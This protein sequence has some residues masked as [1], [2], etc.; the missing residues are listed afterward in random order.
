MVTISH[1]VKKIVRENPLLE[2]FLSRKLINYASLA[3]ELHEKIELEYDKKVKH[4]AI[5]MALRRL[6]EEL[7]SKNKSV[8]KKVFLEDDFIIKENLIEIIIEK[9]IIKN[10]KYNELLK[11]IFDLKIQ[12]VNSNYEIILL[13]NK[14]MYEKIKSIIQ[15]YDLKI[16]KE[17][18]NLSSITIR[19]SEEATST[20][21]FFYIITKELAF[22]NINLYEILSTY[23]ELTLLLEEKQLIKALEVIK[24]LKQTHF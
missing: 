3:E 6:S 14:K 15:K 18:T 1:I 23:T 22:N 13:L 9:E 20:V 7:E 4:T 21:G 12:I 2:E 11:K 24:K 8:I 17:Y 19:I 5:I 10:K 16:K